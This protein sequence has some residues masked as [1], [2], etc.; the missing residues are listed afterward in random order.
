MKRRILFV[1]DGRGYPEGLAGEAIPMESRIVALSDAYD[2]LCTERPYKR[3]LSHGEAL[4][5]IDG[6]VGGHFDPGVCAAFEKCVEDFEVI[7]KE[8]PDEG[9]CAAEVGCMT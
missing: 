5:I 1:D 8:L 4:E 9:C 3:A 6:E 2:A 7:R